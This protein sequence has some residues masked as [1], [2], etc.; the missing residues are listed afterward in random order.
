MP[1]KLDD[2][3]IY[4]AT[5]ADWGM[6]QS[7]KG[8]RFY[9]LIFEIT[10]VSCG[11]DK[12]VALPRSLTRTVRL[13]LDDEENMPDY[14]ERKL[15]KLG[16]NWNYAAGE[17]SEEAT[18]K[19]TWVICTHSFQ[20]NVTYANWD[21]YEPDQQRSK[22]RRKRIDAPQEL[23]DKLNAKGQ[24]YADKQKDNIPF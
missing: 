11:Q 23:L 2:E 6:D 22:Q 16:F 3:G 19:G 20:D 8:R 5:L 7:K 13:F 17:F 14:N 10:H 4:W 12:P 1:Y 18:Q 15:G 9:G 24:Q 21:L